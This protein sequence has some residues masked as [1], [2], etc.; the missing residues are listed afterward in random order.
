MRKNNEWK[1]M[2]RNKFISQNMKTLIEDW[3][4]KPVKLENEIPDDWEDLEGYE[5]DLTPQLGF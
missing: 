2:N 3:N 1:E 5:F 4:K